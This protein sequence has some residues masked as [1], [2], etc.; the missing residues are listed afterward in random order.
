VVIAA[1]G[2]IRGLAAAAGRI[3][4]LAAVALAVLAASAGPAAR[5]TAACEAWVE[6]TPRRGFVGQAVHHRRIVVRPE[7]AAAE[8][9]EPLRFPG[10]R[11]ERPEPASAERIADDDTAR[12]RFETPTLLYP[13]RAGRLVLPGARLRCAGE[14]IE[15]PPRTFE[16]LPWP[17]AGRP[18]GFTGVVGAVSIDAAAE[19]RVALGGSVRVHVTL[20]GPA[21]LW[22]AEIALGAEPPDTEVFRREPRTGLRAGPSAVRHEV[23]DLVPRRVGTLR[24]APLRVP[25][26]DPDRGTYRVAETP[27]LRIEVVA[28]DAPS[29]VDAAA[30]T[31]PSPRS[32]AAGPPAGW[33]VLAVVLAVAAGWIAWRRRGPRAG[34]DPAGAALRAFDDAGDAEGRAVALEQALRARL[35]TRGL[36]PTGST[37]Q[38]L[39]ER[40]PDETV[41]AWVRALAEVERLRFS[42]AALGPESDARLA[43][44]RARIDRA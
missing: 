19:P 36:D 1:G 2:R 11:A 42:G 9:V 10:F 21:N 31:A 23:F 28:A 13:A 6:L 5:A 34:G 22:D 24:V 38:E 20:R 27:P 3:R 44:L 37:T 40:S 33:G 43:A 17:R 15:V 26:L 14:A 25:W 7:R 39:L 12:V 41:R 30:R 16:A 35:A 32:D 4:G 8:W 29:E 18:E